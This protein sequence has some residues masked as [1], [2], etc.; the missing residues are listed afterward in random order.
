MA[1]CPLPALSA[2][3]AQRGL[4]GKAG[5][6][7]NSSCR[8]KGPRLRDQ[9]SW[10]HGCFTMVNCRVGVDRTCGLHGR[11]STGQSFR[12]LQTSRLQAT[13][14]HTLRPYKTRQPAESAGGKGKYTF[15]VYC[16]LDFCYVC[17]PQYKK[18][19]NQPSTRFIGG[20]EDRRTSR[21]FSPGR[22]FG[23]KGKDYA[24]VVGTATEM[25]GTCSPETVT[26]GDLHKSH[27]NLALT[28]DLP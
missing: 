28:P 26:Q 27:G 19:Q 4:E 5:D 7:L 17:P 13:L 24:G 2:A 23:K 9:P 3:T 12:G 1:G 10:H 16:P 11:A 6:A 14:Q 8:K 15:L 25:P 21:F 18:E 22:C 20:Y